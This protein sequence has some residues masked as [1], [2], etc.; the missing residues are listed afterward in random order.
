[1]SRLKIFLASVCL[2]SMSFVTAQEYVLD[3]DWPKPLPEGIEW[4]QVPNV[5]IDADGF[6]YAFH[7]A[8]PP[9]LKF[10]P[11]GNLVD[12]FGSDL[13]VTTPHGFRVTP[14]GN[15]IWAT[16]FNMQRGH[17]ITKIDT[18]GRVLQRFGA[19][20]FSGVGPNTFNGPADVAQAEDGS[21]FVADGHW[22]NRIVKYDKDGRY[23]MEWGKKG[24]GPGEFNL[25]H[26]IVID[27]RGRVLVGDRANLRIQ[28]FTQEGE[29][30]TEWGQFG[31]PSGMFIDG[32][33]MLYVADY[34]ELRGVTYGSA[35]DGTVMGFIQGSEPE[36][37]VVDAEGNVYTGEVTGGE[38]GD[39]SIIRKFIKQ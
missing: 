39:G 11:E 28:I 6:I 10:D 34:Q 29:Y 4:G 24:S 36:G 33:D 12:S 31:R 18:G 21:F 8:D 16:D 38:G 13:W 25:P 20:G 30:I 37:I 22:N 9:V 2:V 7:R 1:M 14:D 27:Q 23:L 32:N 17:T 15:T 35:E 5:T 3:P 19:R 26:T